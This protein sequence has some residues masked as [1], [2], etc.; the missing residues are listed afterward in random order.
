MAEEKEKD[1]WQ[2]E[3]SDEQVGGNGFVLRGVSS[4]GI[5]Y[6]ERGGAVRTVVS[7]E[8]RNGIDLHWLNT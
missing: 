5:F 8:H 4:S 7:S 1:G 3:C 2:R 6:G